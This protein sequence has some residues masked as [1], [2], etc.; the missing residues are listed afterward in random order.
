[1]NDILDE[2]NIPEYQRPNK[3]LLK[4]EAQAALTL[5]KSIVELHESAWL[6]MGFPEQVIQAFH[7]LKDMPQHGAKKQATQAGC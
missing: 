5:A 1:M 7:D 6:E 3:S 4:R 2:Q